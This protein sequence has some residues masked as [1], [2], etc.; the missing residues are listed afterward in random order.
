MEAI[1]RKRRRGLPRRR[2]APGWL[3]LLLALGFSLGCRSNCELVEAELRSKEAQLAD[4]RRELDQRDCL[5]QSLER[6][7]ARLQ[8]MACASPGAPQGP[9]VP[10][11][12]E[13]RLG[14]LT[15]GYDEDPVLPG[16]EALQVILEP[17]DCDGQ[18]V[19]APGSLRLEV[20]EITPQGIKVPLSS[21][22]FPPGELRRKWD[23]PFLGNP[24]YRI[25]VPWK[26]WPMHEKLR[27]VARFTTLDGQCFEADRDVTVR[28]AAQPAV[29]ERIVS[30]PPPPE[31]CP[32]PAGLPGTTPQ[33]VGPHLDPPMLH[34]P[35]PA[36]AAQPTPELGPGP[37][38]PP[39]D[40]PLPPWTSAPVPERPGEIAPA[41]YADPAASP[42]SGTIAPRPRPSTLPPIKLDRPVKANWK[43]LP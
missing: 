33:P 34:P 20:F 19:K 42:S 10:C 18:S 11:V 7:V 22:D 30:P 25:T 6:E 15:G 3:C 31:T 21:W 4:L 1:L 8:Q 27:V 39:T 2:S 29:R 14:R 40:P 37:K 32:A 38:P 23:T 41:N 12:K 26:S 28:L 9:P 13:I 16:D 43:P 24:S 5:V 17:L 35:T 36:P